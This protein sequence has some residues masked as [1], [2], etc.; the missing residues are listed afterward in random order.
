[1]DQV[2]AE[3]A[4]R[5]GALPRRTASSSDDSAL[6]RARLT[7]D[8]LNE[9][10]VDDDQRRLVAGRALLKEPA[11]ND[12]HLAHLSNS[13]GMR[14][15]T[16]KTSSVRHRG[17]LGTHEAPLDSLVEVTDNGDN[18]AAFDAIQVFLT[19]SG[20]YQSSRSVLGD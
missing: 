15:L 6:W 7:T 19:R 5:A 18:K 13:D 4:V 12:E 20:I 3:L 17:N 8:A 11:E 16:Q 9:S 1:L 2:Q 10:A 14:L